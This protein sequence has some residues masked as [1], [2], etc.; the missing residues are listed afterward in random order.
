M[1]VGNKNRDVGSDVKKGI[2]EI[3][4]GKTTRKTYV[5]HKGIDELKAVFDCCSDPIIIAGTDLAVNY[6]NKQFC[7]VTGIASE[8]IINAGLAEWIHPDDRDLLAGYVNGLRENNGLG[9]A[10]PDGPG[11]ICFRLTGSAGKELNLESAGTIVNGNLV[12]N[13]KVTDLPPSPVPGIM[14]GSSELQRMIFD[15]SND[16]IIYLDLK[17]AISEINGKALELYG[18]SKQE[19]LGKHFKDLKLFDRLEQL[20]ILKE[21]KEISRGKELALL[22]IVR[23]KRGETLHLETKA[24]AVKTDGH[25]AGVLIISKDLTERTRY[26]DDR[27]MLFNLSIDMLCIAGFDG[28]FRMLN[29]AWTKTLG[30]TNEE[31]LA[32]DWLN[33]VHPD[34][35]D[36]TIQAGESLFKG[37]PVY[38]FENRYRCRDG[39]YRNLEW[40]SMPFIEEQLIFA[41]VRDITVQNES[42]KKI[43]EQQKKYHL[44]FDKN[45]DGVIIHELNG[46]IID[47]NPKFS[48]MTGYSYEELLSKKV[49]ELLKPCDRNS[50]INIQSTLAEQGYMNYP[51]EFSTKSGGSFQS[52]VSAS[53]YEIDGRKYIQQF[54]RDITDRIS[55]G[56]TIRNSE[57]RLRSIVDGT[58]DSILTMNEDFVINSLNLATTVIYGYE[59]EDVIGKKITNFI[60][61]DSV[62][63]QIEIYHEVGR[64]GTGKK[65]ESLRVKKDGT[66]IPV[67][68]SL[69]PMKR[70]NGDTIGFSSITRDISE[71]VNAEK[72]IRQ[73]EEILRLIIDL[74]PHFIF[75]KNAEGRFLLAN[76]SVADAYG[77][78]TGA[79]VG[80][81]DADFNRNK[82]EVSHFIED[83]NKVLLSG[84]TLVV[85]EE[86]ITDHEGN[87]RYLQTTKIP[88]PASGLYEPALLGVSVDITDIKKAERALKKEKDYISLLMDTTPVSIVRL[89]RE[90]N[91][92][93]AN[94]YSVNTLGI[95]K[96]DIVQRTFNDVQWVILDEDLKPLPDERL[97]FSVVRKTLKPVYNIRHTITL[98]DGTVQY[99]SVNAAPFFDDNGEFDGIVAALDNI[100]EKILREKAIKQSEEKL[101]SIIESLP[102]GLHIY[103]VDE[104]DRLIFSGANPAADRLLGLDNSRFVGLSIEE[105]F[106]PLARTDVPNKYRLTAKTGISCSWEQINYENEDLKGSFE[107]HCFRISPGKMVSL[108]AEISER[109]KD[110]A[111]IIR[112]ENLYRTLFEMNQDGII[113]TDT[114]G[115]IVI[116][117]R[118]MSELLGYNNA[119]ELGSKNITDLIFPPDSREF[120]SQFRDINLTGFIVN[121]GVR[122]QRKSGMAIFA[123]YNATLLYD[124]NDRPYQVMSVVKDITDKKIAEMALKDS[125]LKYRTLTEQLPMGVFRISTGGFFIFTNKS[126]ADMLGFNDQQELIGSNIVD[127]F[128]ECPY[129]V[130]KEYLNENRQDIISNEYSITGRNDA[131]WVQ[132]YLR[133][134]RDSS[135]AIIYLD[136]VIENITERKMNE[137][138]IQK[139]NSELEMRVIERTAQLE[140]TMEE[141]KRENEEHILTQVKLY[142]A[143]KE[144]SEALDKEKE[145][146]NLKTRFISMVSHEYRTPL[147]VIL[148]SA[149][150]LEKYFH[151]QNWDKFSKHIDKIKNSVNVMTRMLEEILFLGRNESVVTDFSNETFDLT[152]FCRT[153][154]SEIKEID[155]NA[156]EIIFNHPSDSVLSNTDQMLLRQILTNLLSNSVKYSS[157]GTKIILEL[158]EED[159]KMKFM[160]RDFG[161]GIPSDEMEY[162]YEP[163]H[164]FSN[165][166]VIQGT[167][168]GLAIVKRCVDKLFGRISVESVLNVGT[169][170][171]VELRRMI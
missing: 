144:L 127:F 27:D 105:A 73:S 46:K 50:I 129:Y 14:N 110:K 149:F 158:I 100:T 8:A 61:A 5:K 63:D 78:T 121:N 119:A 94:N 135:G 39:S 166:G 157:P 21:F 171:T 139:L 151:S 102:M 82:P 60:P 69:S 85:P 133:V 87:A 154:I 38:G 117:N 99:L 115:K 91:L 97:P 142:D 147:T 68:I 92:I 120:S 86:I 24:K 155:N 75:A 11:K 112:S 72:K 47:A 88:F 132:D 44:L 140:D 37:Q 62:N 148:S 150:I 113:L 114:S 66:V 137:A 51:M 56:E 80:K 81:T 3:S 161:I 53:F 101:R 170:F 71:R 74:V 15:S 43:A 131:I 18:A 76:K 59:K 95:N 12:L 136:G 48:E 33:F 109:L 19:V 123:E 55:S 2:K 34:D 145:L 168:L 25:I 93:Y 128:G 90:G 58:S 83:D 138:E 41:V 77:T 130:N 143:Q 17:G 84:K 98:K 167:G 4:R 35:V 29:P 103:T 111:T 45:N 9:K 6:V 30:W 79:I 169:T 22:H 152:D 163:F 42:L 57:E 20:R 23:N 26:R 106:P 159:E 89:D 116:N 67:E 125:E 54:I 64:T 141:L 156:H 134:I 65:F 104:N 32:S 162:L 1:T 126:L 28:R 31:L 10:A 96:D 108:F 36:S 153:T 118:R 124:S 7:T 13:C 146:V 40:N 164:R 16:A 107:V 165:I 52:E 122:F 70:A 49:N 160:V